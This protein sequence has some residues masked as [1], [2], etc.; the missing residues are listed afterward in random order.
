VPE[1]VD[2]LREALD[3]ARWP[4]LVQKLERSRLRVGIIEQRR[5]D[6]WLAATACE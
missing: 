2:D 1:A 5:N 4:T 3:L 6:N